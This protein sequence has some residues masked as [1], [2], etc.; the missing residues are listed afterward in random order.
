MPHPGWDSFAFEGIGTAWEISTPEPLGPAV[1][2][3][4]LDV[5]AD[6]DGCYSRFRTDSLV[7]RLAREAGTVELPAGA[8]QLEAVFRTLYRLSGGTM[9]PLVGSS[10]EQ[11][12]Y[13][14][15]YALVPRGPAAAAPR[16]EDVLEWRGRTLRTASPV[17]LDI[18]AAGKGQLVDMLAGA[19]RAEGVTEYL[20]DGSGDMLHSGPVP[21][22]VG[23]EHPYDPAQA[24]GVVG[25]GSRA[26]CASAANRRSWGD[27][28]H[29]VLDAATGRPVDTT[30]ATWTMADDALT[31]DA[32]ATA[33]FLV[34]PAVLEEE[35]DFE[36]LRV[37]SDGRASFSQGFEGTLFT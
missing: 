13:G 15:D 6:Y 34:E 2:S 26:L 28:L 25:L 14:G 18:G 32:L 27:G 36:W 1:R 3:R 22:R 23:L 29:H 30:V 8:E 7:A 4:L 5:V 9:S 35:F 37:A 21:L 10:L 19:L 33:L 31:A 16:W 12:G 11:L 20:V 24:I 17:V